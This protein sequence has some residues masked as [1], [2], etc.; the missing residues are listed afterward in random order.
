MATSPSGTLA[1]EA[2][3]LREVL[4]QSITHMAPAAAVAFSIPA[5]ISF[6]GGGTPLAVIFAIVA[7]MFVAI[8]I[9]QLAKHLPSAGSFYT[10][11]SRGLHPWVGFLVAWGYAFV[12]PLIVPLLA[13]IF[14]IV[15]SGTLSTEFGWSADL[16]WP[17]ALVC[18]A[19]VF[20]LGYYGIRVSARTGTI[21]GIFEVG[22]FALLAV[23]LIAKAGDG[24]TFEVF[25]TTF[26]NNPDFEGLSGVI[27][28]SVFTILAFIGFEAAAPLAEETSDPRRT[29]GR[30]VVYSCLL[31]GL[32]YVL[33]TYGAT[34]FFGPD[35][36][37]EFP[38]WDALSR[39]V[40][41]AGWVLVFLAIVNSAIANANAGS[42]AATR[43][44]FAMGR[45]RLVPTVFSRVHPR[46]RSP[47]VAV[48]GQLLVAVVVSLWLGFQ[49]DPLT[50]FILVA[51]IIVDVFVP[52][53][54]VV[55]LAC[56]GYFLRH[57]RSEF[58]W[59]LHGLIPILGVLAFIPA[60]FAGAGLPVFDFISRLPSPLSYAGPVA[61]IW[62]LLGVIYLVYL[63]SRDPERIRSTARIFLEEEAAPASAA[64]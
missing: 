46:W 4:F 33:T 37:L 27:A 61:G 19:I 25:G 62:M 38:G 41:G 44:W 60:F 12:E 26:A 32:F 11:V 7:C 43:T 49:Y 59:F 63:N 47:H 48:G 15:V 30:A 56:I 64:G 6:G 28:A 8:S 20:V 14:G 10:Y 24:N 9:G 1:K 54:I 36:M 5:G 2:I 13:L 3:G 55:N 34:V 45:I 42:N 16:W 23:W 29:I 21:L 31:I 53:Y 52:I 58:N 22:V 40:W 50:A 39:D 18:T 35:R 17:W 57:R 51:T